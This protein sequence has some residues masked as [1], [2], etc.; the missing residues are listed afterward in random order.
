M[1][2]TR[3][4]PMVMAVAW[5]GVGSFAPISA[6]SVDGAEIPKEPKVSS[7]DRGQFETAILL[8]DGEPATPPD[9]G[10]GDPVCL[11]LRVDATADGPF[12]ADSFESGDT[13]AW[14]SQEPHL[15]VGHLIDLRFG[16]ELESGF[17]GDHTLH[18]RLTTPKG[19]HY[20]SLSV[21][22]AGVPSSQARARHLEGFPRAMAVHAPAVDEPQLAVELTLPIAGTPILGRAL[23]GRWTVAALIDDALEPC[24]EPATF[25]LA[26]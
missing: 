25:V 5:L 21:P 10:Q 2:K 19:H 14:G 24:L 20:Q 15:S 18:L 1:L 3:C 12:F 6:E 11:A 9:L 16:V 13:S 7:A 17:A 26:R 4:F 8:I 22:I 23:L